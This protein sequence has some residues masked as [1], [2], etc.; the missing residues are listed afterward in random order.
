MQSCALPLLNPLTPKK[1]DSLYATKPTKA[2]IESFLYGMDAMSAWSSGELGPGSAGSG[3]LVAVAALCWV[4]R[5]LHRSLRGA[6]EED[7]AVAV[8]SRRGCSG[9]GGR[10]GLI[11]DRTLPSMP[12]AGGAVAC[13]RAAAEAEAPLRLLRWHHMAACSSGFSGQSLD[14]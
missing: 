5:L 11:I 13:G 10:M 4:L 9:A 3:A 12:T 14:S 8:A 6:G 7:E 2:Q 1:S